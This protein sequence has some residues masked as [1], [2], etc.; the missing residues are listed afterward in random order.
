MTLTTRP[1]D[2]AEL[3][4]TGARTTPGFVSSLTGLAAPLAAAVVTLGVVLVGLG[5]PSYWTDEAA[6]VSAVGRPLPDMTRVLDRQDLVHAAY[7]LL[8]RP[9]AEAFGLGEWSLRTPSALAAAATAAGLVALGRRL[10]GTTAGLASGL[11]FGGLATVSRYAQEARP[12]ALVAAVAVLASYLLVRA[13]SDDVRRRGPWLAAYTA[14]V[15]LLGLLN[16]AALLLVPAHLVT[17]ALTRRRNTALWWR[18]ATAAVAAF[19]GLTPFILAAADQRQ[20]VD[21][22]QRPDAATLVDLVEFLAGSTSMILPVLLL[23][24]AGAVTGRRPGPGG[25]P[26]TALAVPWLV[27]PP[28]ALVAWSLVGTPLFLTR[29]VFFCVPA[30][31]LLLGLGLARLARFGRRTCGPWLGVTALVAMVV[32]LA[33]LTVP[34]EGQIRREDSRLDLR[35]AADVV[36][37]QA[38]PGDAVLYMSGIVRF[39]AS[40]YPDA[41]RRL[42]DAGLVVDPVRA[43]NYTGLERGP[44]D[45][46]AALR[47]AGR[48]WVM[49]TR[50]VRS[51]PGDP[52]ARRK[53]AL[54][55]AGPWRNAGEWRSGGV[56]LTLLERAR[57]R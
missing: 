26:A 6:T 14:A 38:R 16:L 25:V 4:V 29:Y 42:R 30:L 3:P 39:G 50:A 44:E 12:F 51:R 37:R 23:A 17:L 2:A 13:A 48:V 20:Q 49:T 55:G 33:V 10:A 27:L 28:V 5:R 7:Y 1:P 40:A 53:A 11:A 31:A 36:R 8:M 34:R 41:F 19:T 24:G 57:R 47:A 52:I 43:G 54:D 22:L 18:W 21:W 32:L 9:W 15:L 45:T 56:V 35:S 46:R